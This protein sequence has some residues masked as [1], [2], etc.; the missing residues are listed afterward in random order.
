MRSRK[1]KQ[2][3]TPYQSGL[4]AGPGGTKSFLQRCTGTLTKAC[5]PIR[6]A[7]LLKTCS[8][9]KVKHFGRA[10]QTKHQ[11]AAIGKQEAAEARKVWKKKVEENLA[12]GPI[13]AHK[14]TKP[15]KAFP[16]KPVD[17]EDGPS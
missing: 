12:K 3:E 7:W 1:Q 9:Y 8:T 10:K 13:W 16:L 14:T 4:R 11:A 17:T 5:Y 15:R 6:T 2:Q